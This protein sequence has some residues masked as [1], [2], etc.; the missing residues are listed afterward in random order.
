M[1][2]SAP[3]FSKGGPPACAPGLRYTPRVGGRLLAMRGVCRRSLLWFAFTA[4]LCGCGN[5]GSPPGRSSGGAASQPAA[6]REVETVAP[7]ASAR[8]IP[9]IGTLF[10][11]DEVIVATKV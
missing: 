3:R 7:V 4:A 5:G 1:P 10:A 2:W 8:R 6:L 9:V 11:A